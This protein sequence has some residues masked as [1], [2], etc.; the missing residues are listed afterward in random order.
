MTWLLDLD[1]VVWL[2]ERPIPGAP[3]A[4]KRL[5]HAGERVVFFTNNSGPT[6][7]EYLDKLAGAGI[8]GVAAEDLLTSA[9]AAAT[10][11]PV[12]STAAVV[13]G[14][15]V[16]EALAA[17]HID[18]RDAGEQPASV[19]VG[20]TVELSY[21][22]LAAAA[23]AI[24]AGAKFVATNTDAT[25]PTPDGPV[26]GAGAIVSFLATASGREPTVAGKPAQPAVQLVRERVGQVDVVVGDRPDTDGR[27]AQAAGA[28]FALVL[29]GVTRRGDLPVE[30]APDVVGDDL[31]AVVDDLLARR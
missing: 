16:R 7:A 28:R 15:G 27:F 29:S 8:D 23:S 5:R 3:D 10:L 21:D 6:M 13:G 11:L 31:A 22:L 14:A 1:G 26:P 4:I 2:A 20:R 24:R 17:R 19:V 30:P 9:Q 25:F 18:L 12:G